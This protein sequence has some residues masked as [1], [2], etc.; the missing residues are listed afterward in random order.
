[1]GGVGIFAAE[2]Y[3]DKV[4]EVRRVSDRVI[5]LKVLLG[6]AVLNVVSA[7]APQA[8][9]TNEEKEELWVLLARTVFELS[10]C[11]KLVVCVDLNAHVGEDA[12]RFG[13]VHG[14]TGN[15]FGK[16]NMEGEMTLECAEANELAV[17]N[18]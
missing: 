18:T 17:L 7:Y 10:D 1:V 2:Q 3:I 12:D 11:E 16:R 15:G 14:G 5:I 6:K 8:S 9:R 4:V 13:M